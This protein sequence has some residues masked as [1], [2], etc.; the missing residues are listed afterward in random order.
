MWDISLDI[1][2]FDSLLTVEVDLIPGLL[3]YRAEEGIKSSFLRHDG[4]MGVKFR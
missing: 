2:F 1:Y 4:S 3:D